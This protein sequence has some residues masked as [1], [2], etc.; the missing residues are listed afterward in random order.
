[1]FL[2]EKRAL[3][4]I[5][6][7][8]KKALGDELISVTAFGSRVRGDFKGDSDLDVL[9]IV[10]ERNR[11]I[12][13]RIVDI[14]NE[15]EIRTGIPFSPVVKSSELFEKEKKFNT[16]FYRNIKNEGRLFYGKAHD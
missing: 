8:L 14:F 10:R 16:T 2:E 3:K 4:R 7:R 5:A 6:D 15:E 13:D 9:V 11:D 12:V 1:M